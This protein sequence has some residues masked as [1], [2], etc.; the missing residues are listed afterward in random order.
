MS[1]YN[2]GSKRGLQLYKATIC[3]NPQWA[4][5]QRPKVAFTTR[6]VP[7]PPTPTCLLP[8]MMTDVVLL[9]ALCRRRP[10][11]LLLLLLPMVAT[12]TL[13]GEEAVGD[14]R[15]LVRILPVSMPCLTLGLWHRGGMSQHGRRP[16]PFQ[17]PLQLQPVAGRRPAVTWWPYSGTLPTSMG[18][19]QGMPLPLHLRRRLQGPPAGCTSLPPCSPRVRRHHHAL[20]SP[21]SPQLPWK[22]A[23]PSLIPRRGTR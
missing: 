6:P 3:Y 4:A 22:G 21:V 20:C 16:C 12:A 1:W 11:L 10:Q 19:P 2:V 9:T 7:P 15:S 13:L 23:S 18:V 17:D 8:V 14:R 5:H